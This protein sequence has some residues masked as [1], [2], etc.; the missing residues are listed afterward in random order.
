MAN[1]NT[2]NPHVSRL[3]PWQ[4]RALENGRTPLPE[5]QGDQRWL[6]SPCHS[7]QPAGSFT[8]GAT[9][10]TPAG[11]SSG[12]ASTNVATPS[13]SYRFWPEDEMRH[14]IALRNGGATWAMI[15]TEFPNRTHE[16]IK[17]AYHKRRHAIEQQMENEATGATSS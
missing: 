5:A 7:Q 10:T 4:R 2:K 13:F 14:L 11:E 15:Y 12:K 3:R 9:S 16:A 17:Q 1:T 8:Q 6:S